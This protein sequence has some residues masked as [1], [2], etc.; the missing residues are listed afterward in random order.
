ME[1]C[2]LPDKISLAKNTF[3]SAITSLSSLF[4]F[5]LLIIAGRHLGSV[6]YGI[7]TFAL[8]FVFI[9]EIFTDFGLRGLSQRTVARDKSLSVKYFGNLLIWK[10]VLSVIIFVILVLTINA[11]KSSPKT[12]FAVYILGFATI[13]R[14]FKWACRNFFRAFERFDLDSLTMCIER[15]ALLVVG[16]VVLLRGGGLISFAS[17]F[18]IVRVFDLILTFAILNWKVVKI[19]PQFDFNFLKKLQIEALPFGFFSI[20]IVLYSYVDTVMLS[21]ICTDAD[22]GWYN[23]AYKIYEGLT[24]FPSIICGVLYPRL[25]Q[26]FISNKKAHSVLSL[27]ASKYLFII[28]FPILICGI[29]LSNNIINILFGKEFQNS[30]IALQILLLGIV[31]VFQIWL[32]QTLFNSIDKQKSVMY[33]GLTGLI[34]NI[35]LNLLLIP[36]Y[37]FKGAATTTVLSE[38]VV[39]TIYYFYLYKSYY[40]FPL[41]KFSLKPFFASLIVGGFLWKFHTVFLIPSIVFVFFLYIALLFCFKT[42][43]HE[44]LDLIRKLLRRKSKISGERIKTSKNISS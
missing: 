28:S 10:L 16:G 22:V 19:V 44:E 25:S 18:V 14:S 23:A 32:F 30:V 6:D 3:Y 15:L 11:L 7:F 33:I 31:F 42:F 41:L 17:T 29:I 36:R 26:L 20:I 35:I 2:I 24:V 38:L 8:A 43:D 4:L 5:V 12:R 13:L 21:F 9:F 39:F 1:K 40:K 37:S 34:I 27:R